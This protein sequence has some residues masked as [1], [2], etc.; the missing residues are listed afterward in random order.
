MSERGPRATA[1]EARSFPYSINPMILFLRGLFILVLATMLGVTTWASLHTPLFAIPRPVFTHPWF[2]ATLADAYWGFV[3]F[4][5]WVAWKEQT[6]A[7][8]ILWFIA[9]VLLGNIAMS[10]YMLRQL[11][12]LPKQ[13]DLSQLFGTRNRGSVLLPSALAGLGMA[14]V[15]LA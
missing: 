8:R 6:L 15:L 12:A 3:T 4:F 7:A 11:F 1:V 10:V 14:V 2:I 5:V 13:A 9:I